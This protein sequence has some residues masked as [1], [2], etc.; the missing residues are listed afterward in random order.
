M[1]TKIKL[2]LVSLVIEREKNTANL[3][4]ASDVKRKRKKNNNNNKVNK[5]RENWK[6]MTIS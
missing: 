2:Y 3:L 4:I 6:Y 5:K 1:N